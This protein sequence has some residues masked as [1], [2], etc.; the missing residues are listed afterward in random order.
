MPTLSTACPLDCPDSCTLEVEIE[1]GVATRLDASDVNAFTQGFICSKVRRFPRRVY[2]EKRLRSPL[3]R[4]GAKGAGRFESISWDDALDTITSEIER[5]R[6]TSG[7]EAIVPLSYGGSNGA[8]TQDNTD[9]RLFSRL[10]ASRLRRSVCAAATGAAA[11][12]LYGGMPGVALDD[13]PEAELIVIWGANPSA[14][15]IHLVPVVLEA[16]RRGATLIVIDPRRTPLAAKADLHLQLRPGTDL[17][18]ALSLLKWLFDNGRADQDFLARHT[19]GADELAAR[20]ARWSMDE[21]SHVAG[22]K[23]RDLQQLAESY[24]AA[25]PALIRCGWGLERNRNG[26]SAVAAVLALP[27]VAGKFGVRGGGYTLSNSRAFPLRSDKAAAAQPA[28]S[29]EINMN[30]IGRLLNEPVGTPIELLFVYNNNPVATLPDQVAVRRGLARKDLFTVV[31]DQ[32]HTDTV[33]YADIVLPATTFLEHDDLRVGY[34]V[35]MALRVQPVIDPVGEAR[36]NHAVFQDLCTRLGLDEPGDPKGVAELTR[37][38]VADRPEVEAELA[39]R[40][41]SEPVAGSRPIQFADVHPGTTD[42]KVHLFPSHLDSEAPVGLYGF[43]ADPATELYPLALL[44]PSTNRTT[45]SSLG[46]LYADQAAVE[47]SAGDAE[48]RGLVSGSRARVFN[49]HGEVHCMVRLS[50]NVRPGVAVLP[51][52]I[53]GHNTLNGATSNALVSD[54]LTDLGGGATFNDCRVQIAG[55]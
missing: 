24:S 17:P 2:G 29:R 8:L 36:P 12:G 30:L 52:G 32:V 9:A 50:A 21:A 37:A 38:L 35:Q 33:D 6:T 20:A 44:S 51:K 47:I 34:G 26:G 27:A 7:P 28:D 49:D 13:Y 46:E 45:N 19:T 23:A 22:V 5:V 41:L 14:S 40:G 39:N 4:V 54:D 53:W 10:G 31:F 16:R 1:D 3:R 42:G 43:R 48:S 15:G 55:L 18:V 25:A 11:T